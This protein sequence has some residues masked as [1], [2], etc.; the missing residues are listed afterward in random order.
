[1]SSVILLPQC[2]TI[3]HL[4]SFVHIRFPITPETV[5]LVKQVI[6]VLYLCVCN[7]PTLKSSQ[8]QTSFGYY[9]VVVIFQLKAAGA[10]HDLARL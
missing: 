6:A 7:K 10:Q 4:R 8:T 2:L 3:V 9:L 5:H 1:M